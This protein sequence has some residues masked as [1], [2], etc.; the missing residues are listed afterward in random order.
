ML[1]SLLVYLKPERSHPLET[2][3]GCSVH[4]L[5]LRIL[6]EVEPTLSR[7]LHSQKRLKPFTL[8]CPLGPFKFSSGKKIVQGDK[9][10]WVRFTFLTKELFRAFSKGLSFLRE[11]S[12]EV[13]LDGELFELVDVHFQKVCDSVPD[14]FGYFDLVNF[15]EKNSFEH[16]PLFSTAFLSPTTF[17]RGK[18]NRVFPDPS[19]VFASYLKKWNCFSDYSFPE[20]EL[21]EVIK[22]EE[23]FVVSEYRL[24]SDGYDLGNSY[25]IGFRGECKVRILGKIESELLCYLRTLHLFS[26]YSGTGQGTTMGMGITQPIVD[27]GKNISNK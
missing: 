14:F 25:R 9:T 18:A 2:S 26:F 12:P 4:G 24:R 1:T 7:D 20:K 22:N 3:V 27:T 6:S 16:P 5:F 17:R 23:R 15:V 10:Y 21:L 8:S 19:L 11:K 13:F